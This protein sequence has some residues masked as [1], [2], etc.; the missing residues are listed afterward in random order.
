M[1]KLW[2]FLIDHLKKDFTI[3]YYVGIALFLTVSL[4]INYYLQLENEVIDSFHGRF[5]SVLLY[6]LLYSFAYYG[7]ILISCATRQKTFSFFTPKF[8]CLSLIGLGL[9]ALSGG[10]P[11]VSKIVRFFVSDYPLI[12]WSYSV[13]NNL[14][15][16]II[17]TFPLLIIAYIMEKNKREYF[18]I[19]PAFDV[20]PYLTI[21]LIIIPFISIASLEEGLGNYYPTYKTNS[22]AE[23]MNWP[24]WIPAF[25]YELSYAIDFFNV[26][27]IFRGFMV[28]G[29]SRIIGKEAIMPM[30]TTYCFLHFGKPA[31]EAISSIFGGYILGV[32][33]LYTRSIWGGVI[34]HIGVAWTME[35]AAYLAKA[36]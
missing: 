19:T 20:M 31:G 14:I 24:S 8:W 13:S 5:I 17:N 30:V 23:L 34:I 6:F 2:G 26:E 4:V 27:F 11:Y 1:K 29:I 16:L 33:A 35:L 28:I 22:V 7:A 9:L 15:S 12:S 32:I 18:G 21:L 25:I 10:F 36:Y 3:S